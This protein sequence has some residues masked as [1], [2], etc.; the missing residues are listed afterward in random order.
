MDATADMPRRSLAFGLE[1]AGYTGAR[2]AAPHPGADRAGIGA[3]GVGPC[4]AEGR[5]LPVRAVPHRYRGVPP[6]R[7]DRSPLP[8]ER[9][10]RPCRGRG[11][12]PP[13][14]AADRG[15][16][17]R[18]RRSAAGRRRGRRGLHAVGARQARRH[19]L[20]RAHR[21]RRSS[22]RR[23]RLQHHHRGAESQR[24][25][26]RQVPVRRWRAGT[27]RAGARS[28]VRAG[29]GRQ[30]GDRRHQRAA[31][32]GVRRHGPQV[33]PDRRAGHAARDPQRGRARPA[34]S[35]T[36]SACC[37]APSSP[38]SSSSACR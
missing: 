2:L 4:P 36:A 6:L 19:R 28:Q 38:S 9:V 33:A 20:C 1:R 30:A 26:R 34:R 3:G 14:E 31:R 21:A 18:H 17:P 11:Q 15:L 16:P 37:S 35:T 10:R 24:D 5:R 8:L 32:Q 23:S 13:P 25:R 27:G 22:R 12:G 29:A 7:G